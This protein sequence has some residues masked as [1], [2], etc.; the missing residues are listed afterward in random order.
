[1]FSICSSPSFIDIVPEDGGDGEVPS[2]PGVARSHHVLGVEHLL[3]QL[4]HSEGAV[5]LAASG[6]E[7][8]EAGHEEVE[9]W[10]GHHVDRQLPK[11]SV[12]L[13][14]EPE[15]SGDPR[16]C[17]GDEVVEVSVGGWSTSGS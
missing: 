16:H 5:L 13:A 4:G 11:V 3:G 7:G 12:K 14:R 17:E 1:M 6:S 9:P 8:G 2:V 15:A 10:E